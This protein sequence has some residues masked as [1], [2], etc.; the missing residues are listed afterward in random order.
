[1]R[2][3]VRVHETTYKGTH[4]SP[5]NLTAYMRKPTA[6]TPT[7]PKLLMMGDMKMRKGRAHAAPIVTVR[8][9]RE[10][11]APRSPRN[12]KRNASRNP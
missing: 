2:V 12:Q 11:E 5:A 3:S 8:P 10:R 9:M 4:H 1:M 7:W 6:I